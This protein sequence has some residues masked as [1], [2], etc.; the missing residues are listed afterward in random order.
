MKV[1]RVELKN[2][3]IYSVR[4]DVSVYGVQ[5]ILDAAYRSRKY[6][7]AARQ[8]GTDDLARVHA[9]EI[10]GEWVTHF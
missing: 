9:V 1:Y 7:K 2:W 10:D 4:A 5:A 6:R 3:A 8:Q